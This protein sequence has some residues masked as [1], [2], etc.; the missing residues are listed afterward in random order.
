MSNTHYHKWLRRQM[1]F[2][3]S[4]FFYIHSHLLFNQTFILKKVAGAH[5]ECDSNCTVSNKLTVCVLRKIN[6]WI[7]SKHKMSTA[8]KKLIY[9]WTGGL[10]ARPTSFF[11]QLD[12][13]FQFIQQQQQQQ[14]CQCQICV[15]FWFFSLFIHIEWYVRVC[16][17]L[18]SL[19][20]KENCQ[21]PRENETQFYIDRLHLFSPV[22]VSIS[23]CVCAWYDTEN[24]EHN[25]NLTTCFSVL[26]F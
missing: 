3:R 4:V 13:L 5:F 26:V 15:D 21:T 12:D 25:L 14:N 7:N 20:H 18:F 9:N 16:E 2:K 19:T 10:C 24:K 1:T 6:F 23:L 22:Y 8:K 17:S 11:E